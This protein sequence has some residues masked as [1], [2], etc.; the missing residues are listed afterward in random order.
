MIKCG[1]AAASHRTT[2]CR[3]VRSAHLTMRV[4]RLRRGEWMALAV[5]LIW[6]VGLIVAAA[7]DPAYQSTTETSS[8]TVTHESATLVDEN[9]PAI[10][11]PVAVPLLVTVIVGYALWRREASRGAGPIAWTFTV[12]LAGFNVVAMASIG[13]LMLPVTAALG[14]AFAKRQA[15][16]HGEAARGTTLPT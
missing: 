16:T 14:V 13:L 3:V 11:V 5:A 2:C 10:L 1:N 6:C 12:L 7:L 4:G 9:G 8:G 15:P